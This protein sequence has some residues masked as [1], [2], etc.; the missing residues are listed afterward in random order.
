MLPPAPDAGADCDGD[1]VLDIDDACP[2]HPSLAGDARPCAEAQQACAL[3][4]RGEGNFVGAD[5]RGCEAEV[6]I[7]PAQSFVDADMTCARL[8]FVTHDEVELMPF[9]ARLVTLT[10]GIRFLTD[11]LAGDSYF[12]IHR[13]GQ[14]LDRA[15]VQFEMVRQMEL[16]NDRMA[17]MAASV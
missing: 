2:G 9:A 13:P 17:Q 15:R 1:G 4:A 5:L 6:A 3:L 8:R 16:Q 11:H 10:I 12:R 14:N 7:S